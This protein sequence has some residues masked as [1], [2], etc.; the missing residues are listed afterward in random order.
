MPKAP[1]KGLKQFFLDLKE[2]RALMLAELKMVCQ[3]WLVLTRRHFE[4]VKPVEPLVALHHRIETLMAVA[5]L[6]RLSDTVKTKYSGVFNAIP[7]L[8]ELPT[9]VY[10]RINWKT[11]QKLLQ[12]IHTAHHENTRRLGQRWFNSTSMLAGYSRLTSN[13]PHLHS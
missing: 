7:H 1:K 13:M 5:Q 6:D 3:E 2:D 4:T 10:C 8:D 12:H 11:H 9:D